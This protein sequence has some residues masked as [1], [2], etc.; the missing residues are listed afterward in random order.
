MGAFTD[1]VVVSF[2][3]QTLFLFTLTP[4]RLYHGVD[5][6]CTST[7]P[8][9]EHPCSPTPAAVAS[10]SARELPA[11]G[12][13]QLGHTAVSLGKP[14]GTSEQDQTAGERASQVPGALEGERLEGLEGQQGERGRSWDGLQNPTKDEAVER[15][16]G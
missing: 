6:K 4:L 11:L 14:P 13:D 7:L 15:E 12:Q 1:Q 2:V 8:D 5:T 10:G 9:R 3:F 16:H